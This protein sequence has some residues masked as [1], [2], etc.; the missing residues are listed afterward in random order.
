MSGLLKRALRRFRYLAESVLS[1]ATL[2]L[3]PGVVV[4]GNVS[5]SYGIYMSFTDGG[6]CILEDGV[7]L[8][9][10]AHLVARGGRLSIGARTLIGQGSII[11][12]REKIAIGADCLIAEYVTIRDQNHV[13]G[14]GQ[15]TAESGFVN[16]PIIV[17]D[18]VWIGAKATILPGVRI[19]SGS[20]IGAGAVVTRN[21]PANSV[22]TGVPARVI[23]TIGHE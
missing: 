22:A 13:F 6:D 9:R 17:E 12:S 10:Y 4:N 19:G 11:V 23:R 8:Q 3:T 2:I 20:V 15:V 18:N 21:I 7:S 16:S 5:T 1:K 14:P